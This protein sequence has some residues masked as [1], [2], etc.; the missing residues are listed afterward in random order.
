MSDGTAVDEVM[1]A[2]HF[3]AITG[4]PAAKI[5]GLKSQLF[6]V[7]GEPERG[8]QPTSDAAYI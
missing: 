4:Q 2:M 8:V 7:H 6:R 5:V 1:R 3:G